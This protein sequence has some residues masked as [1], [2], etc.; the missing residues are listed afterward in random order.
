MLFSANSEH[1]GQGKSGLQLALEFRVL[2]NRSKGL[3]EEAVWRLRY[4]AQR[5]T[6]GFKCTRPQGGRDREK[7]TEEE[8]REEEGRKESRSKSWCFPA[9]AL[10]KGKPASAAVWTT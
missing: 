6:L 4:I 8:R 3:M 1:S 2:V 7:E 9:L 5:L 10:G